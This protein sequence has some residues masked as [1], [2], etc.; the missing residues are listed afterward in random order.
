MKSCKT[1]G[2]PRKSINGPTRDRHAPNITTILMYTRIRRRNFH[3][4]S[5]LSSSIFKWSFTQSIAI[6]SYVC[7]VIDSLKACVFVV[8]FL[9]VLVCCIC[10]FGRRSTTTSTINRHFTYFILFDF[11]LMLRF[12]YID[13]MVYS[14]SIHWRLHDANANTP[15]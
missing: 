8:V 7:F 1:R 6:Y 10:F 11:L 5:S 14:L 13:N 9:W 12:C 15:I 4:Q 2:R 3:C